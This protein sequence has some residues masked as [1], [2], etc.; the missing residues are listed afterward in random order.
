MPTFTGVRKEKSDDGG[1]E[2]I[3]GVWTTGRRAPPATSGR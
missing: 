3:E 2:H 1:H